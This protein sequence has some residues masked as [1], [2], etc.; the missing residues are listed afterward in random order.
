[1]CMGHNSSFSGYILHRVSSLKQYKEEKKS[2]SRAIS[3]LLE[4]D[5]NQHETRAQAQRQ[6]VVSWDRDINKGAKSSS[7]I[8]F[9]MFVFFTMVYISGHQR[10]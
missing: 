5:T 10:F 2:R 6:K 3:D 1:M 8:S 9:G 7:P 4:P